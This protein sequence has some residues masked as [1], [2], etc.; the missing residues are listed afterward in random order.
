LAQTAGNIDEAF[1]HFEDALAYCL[2]A[3]FRPELAWTCHDYAEGLL[4]RNL[5]GDS[6]KALLLIEESLAISSDLGMR[7]LM[8]RAEAVKE[9]LESGPV[10]TP[11]HPDGLT[12]REVEVLQLICDGMTD[13]EIGEN[14]FISIK[15]VGNHVSNILNKTSTANR[16]EA[17]AY[18]T[19][20]SIVT[21]DVTG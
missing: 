20:H 10:T 13:R 8:E 17:A 4:Q 12:R 7:P 14:L 5:P 2:K 3:G 9:R 11:A 6:N 19:R 21:D 18:A 16:T 15:T 1:G